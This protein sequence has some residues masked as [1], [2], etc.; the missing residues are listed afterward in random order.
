MSSGGQ[1]QEKG[2]SHRLS[3]SD[4]LFQFNGGLRSCSR[5]FSCVEPMSDIVTS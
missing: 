3:G 2:P 1:A 5:S 4:F